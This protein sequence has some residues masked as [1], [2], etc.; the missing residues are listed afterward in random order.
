MLVITKNTAEIFKNAS[1]IQF[2]FHLS[3]V[4]SSHRAETASPLA[5]IASANPEPQTSC[6]HV[7]H[8][9][10]WNGCIQTCVDQCNT[11]IIEIHNVLLQQHVHST[12]KK[13]QKANLCTS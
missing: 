7:L 11:S 9:G 2:N 6:N 4:Y 5:D 12:M 13:K 3:V 10:T 8:S 1:S